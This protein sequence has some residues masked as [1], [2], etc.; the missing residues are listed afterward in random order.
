LLLAGARRA[1]GPGRWADTTIERLAPVTSGPGDERERPLA[2]V[3]ALD[4]SGSMGAPLPA[5]ATRYAQ[6]VDAV[7]AS[8]DEA[9][10]PL[11]PGDLLGVLTFAERPTVVREPTPLAPGD[12]RAL[13]EALGSRRHAPGGGTDIGAALVRAL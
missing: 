13:R 2:V 3:V 9:R 10:G 12:V 11:R 7:A 4:G 8:L 5:G 1:F 6:A